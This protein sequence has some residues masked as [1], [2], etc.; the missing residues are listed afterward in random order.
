[1]IRLAVLALCMVVLTGCDSKK[2]EYDYHKESNIYLQA[3]DIV[4]AEAILKEGLIRL[5]DSGLLKIDLFDLYV[6]TDVQK[7]EQYLAVVS[8]DGKL[9]AGLYSQLAAK[10]FNDKN[11]IK[12]NKYYLLNGETNLISGSESTIPC[13]NVAV[14]I[15]AYRNAAA[16]GSNLGN[17]GLVK[18]ALDRMANVAKDSNCAND[19]AVKIYIAEVQSWLR[20]P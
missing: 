17:Q 13:M 15:E 5:P 10:Y 19:G 7:A 9:I 1:M 14:A 16:S 3:N 6:K 11:Y 8:L 20:Y 2:S 12:A 4:K 18:Q